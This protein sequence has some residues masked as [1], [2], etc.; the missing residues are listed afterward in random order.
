MVTRE[1][2]Y[3]SNFPT[4]GFIHIFIKTLMQVSKLLKMLR[5]CALKENGNSFYRKFG[6]TENQGQNILQKARQLPHWYK[7]RKL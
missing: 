2:C 6:F 5:Y 1:T 7:A 3:V 4:T